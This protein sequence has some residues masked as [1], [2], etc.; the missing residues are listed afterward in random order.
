MEFESRKR[1]SVGINIVPLINIVFL[2]LIFFMLTSTLSTPD[3]FDVTLPESG[4]GA[5]HASEPI[6][7]LIGPDGTV[8]VNNLPTMIGDLTQEIERQIAEGGNPEVM[9][10]ADSLATSSD[11]LTVLRRARAAGVE[12]V[13]LATQAKADK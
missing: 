3:E 5:P 4:S 10:K 7:V 12:R 9:V 1:L 8:A 11:V 6:V 2:L 13:A